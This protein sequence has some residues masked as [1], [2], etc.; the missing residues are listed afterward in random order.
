MNQD[1]ITELGPME[2]GVYQYRFSKHRFKVL[3]VGRHYGLDVFITLGK[4]QLRRF[5]VRSWP[6]LVPA[7]ELVGV[8]MLP[9]QPYCESERGFGEFLGQWRRVVVERNGIIRLE[10]VHAKSK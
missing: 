6:Y 2:G 8:T 9:F 5:S 7:I 4:K 3:A 1:S 10:V